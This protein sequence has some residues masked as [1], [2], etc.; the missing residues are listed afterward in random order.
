MTTNIIHVTK[1]EFD[2]VI[3]KHS[4]ILLD[5]WGERCAPCHT[6]S[7]V[8]EEIA[9]D[10]PDITFVKI[11]TDVEFELAQEF[12]IRSIP[13]IMILRENVVVYAD[14]GALPAGVLREMLDQTKALDMEKVKD[15]LKDEK[16]K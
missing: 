6:F 12:Q 15:Q 16:S 11:N 7:H 2:S 5:F 1:A 4:I 10:Y 3:H 14:S 13:F 9:P 8:L